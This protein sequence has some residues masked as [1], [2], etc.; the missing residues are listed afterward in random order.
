MIT[1]DRSQP[2]NYAAD[3]VRYYGVT[4]ICH[5]MTGSRPYGDQAAMDRGTDLHNIFALAVASYA[6][7]CEPPVVPTLYHG[8]HQSMMQWIDMVKPLPYC[9]EQP[10][11]SSIRLTPFAGTPDLLALIHYRGNQTLALI[12]LK[13]GG[14][15]RWHHA[16]I[17]AYWKLKG[18]E[19]AE[20]AGILYLNADGEMP[21]FETVK[22]NG[23]DFTAFQSALNLLF[24]RESA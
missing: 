19:K 17:M 24:W 1:I 23:R 6:G 22:W 4:T 7:R 15:A 13:T 3:G 16:Q 9:I 11:I 12:D 20:I 8:Y 18:Y 10:S 14:K 5:A 2:L 21:T